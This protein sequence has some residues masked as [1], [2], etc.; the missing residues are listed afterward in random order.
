MK[1][2]IL[3]SLVLMFTLLHGVMAQTRNISG[4]VTD[5]ATGSGLPGV[6]ILLKGTSNG[7]ST[8]ADGAF[9]LAVP[10]TGG[11][12]VFSSVGMTSQERA[13]GNESQFTVALVTDS[14]QLN[15]VVVTGSQPSAT[16]FAYV[17]SPCAWTR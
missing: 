6:T 10:E 9:S 8:N 2:I 16:C 13:I 1:K 17:R 3:M 12:L 4:R 14:K 7:V 5:Q 11:T 15:E